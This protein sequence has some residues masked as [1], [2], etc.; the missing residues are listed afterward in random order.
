MRYTG[1]GGRVRQSDHVALTCKDVAKNRGFMQD[2]L[3][4]QLREQIKF[5][6][7]ASEIGS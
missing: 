3:G 6:D 1:R 2:V 7:G 5:D 4:L